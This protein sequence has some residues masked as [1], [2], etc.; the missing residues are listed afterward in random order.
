[1]GL[2]GRGRNEPSDVES[3][4]D[5]L[6]RQRIDAASELASLKQALSER[7]A[8]VHQRERELA[9]ALARVEK[10]EQ[11]LGAS[12]ERGSR[13]DSVRLRLAEAKEGR[14]ALD[15]RRAELDE[16]ERQLVARE[17]A[18]ASGG[19]A[20]IVTPQP[21]SGPDPALVRE[22]EAREA[23]LDEGERSLA[24]REAALEARTAELD[25]RDATLT[26]RERERVAPTREPEPEP[27]PRTE[28]LEQIEARLAELRAAEQAFVRTQHEL[29]AR[30]DALTEREAALAERD[31]A[32]STKE[33][34]PKAPDL[35]VL[36]ARIRRLEQGGRIGREEAQTFSSGLRALQDRGL[37]GNRGP[38]EPLH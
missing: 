9:D 3:E 20:P 21:P 7:V 16:R 35:E 10:R 23:A 37:R 24:G 36:E 34:P 26:E 15:E 5:A 32:L 18:L 33:T 11:K 22:L 4:R 14:A 17:A 27:E 13:L 29:A 25:A 6:R 2:K 1:M 38:N 8:Q 30:S 31:R 12:D 19:E 28:E